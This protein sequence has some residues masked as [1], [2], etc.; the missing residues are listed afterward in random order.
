MM[1]EGAMMHEGFRGG[2]MQRLLG[3]SMLASS[4]EAA[5]ALKL[6]PKFYDLEWMS[7]EMNLQVSVTHLFFAKTII[8]IIFSAFVIYMCARWAKSAKTRS[9]LC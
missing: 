7:D 5:N 3:V 4:A 8:A 2:P 1:H 9:F 6:N